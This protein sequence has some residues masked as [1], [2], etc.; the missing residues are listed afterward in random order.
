M[1]SAMEKQRQEMQGLLEQQRIEFEARLTEQTH[2]TQ[3][4]RQLAALQSR[5]ESMHTCK[6]L[7]DEE[8]C[9]VEDIIAD[10]V[11]E[12]GE[13]EESGGEQVAKLV[14]LSERLTSDA[15][16]ARQLRRKFA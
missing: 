2:E 1:V 7:S 8:L 3:R 15:A 10:S 9:K 6:L 16:L 5:L 12:E 4:Q 13:D 14:A 11:E